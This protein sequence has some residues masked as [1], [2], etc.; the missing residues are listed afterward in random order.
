LPSDAPPELSADLE[1]FRNAAGLGLKKTALLL[2]G[3]IAEALLL[4]RH[5]DRSER[6][7]GLAKLVD[8]AKLKDCSGEMR[9][10]SSRLSRTIAT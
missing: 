2:S 1:E 5:T 4:L 8:E 6:G 10:D 9:F 3:A 7:P